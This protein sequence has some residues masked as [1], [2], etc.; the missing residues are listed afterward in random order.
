MSDDRDDID[1]ALRRAMAALD[2]E[3]PAGY[4]EALP[5]RTLAR[6]DD[7]AIGELPEE[8]TARPPR[9][10]QGLRPPADDDEDD[11]VFS[12]QIMA[13]VELPEPEGKLVA[14]PRDDRA[15]ASSAILRA[16]EQAADGGER[17]TIDPEPASTSS[18]RV[19]AVPID[20]D[21]ELGDPGETRIAGS[22]L[23]A[24]SASSMIAVLPVPPVEPAPPAAAAMGPRS[25]GAAAS[26]TEAGQVRRRRRV[27]AAVVGIGGI[28]LAAVAMMYLRAGEPAPRSAASSAASSAPSTVLNRGPTSPSAVSG[29]V[30][31]LA[32]GSAASADPVAGGNTISSAKPTGAA[33]GPGS[34]SG[35]TTAAAAGSGAVPGLTSG[36]ASGTGKLDE[37]LKRPG[38][39][40]PLSK[41]GGG[42]P[43]AQPGTGAA[44][45]GAGAVK[46][47]GADE[48]GKKLK[49]SK[50]RPDRTSLSG[51]DIERAMTAVAG[52]ARA[53]FAGTRGT[54]SLR[55]TV[56][57]SGRIV[58]VTVAGPFAGTPEGACVERA[59][60]TATFPPRSGAPRSFDYSYLLS[61]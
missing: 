52:Q 23:G 28:G 41:T 7:P 6:L 45:K 8:P 40:R 55:L 1:A 3:A 38:S 2:G 48:P 22:D 27:R 21:G 42:K 33:S 26:L 35:A 57:P 10:V 20:A 56:A 59:V 24:R 5:A 31:S 4:F 54:A 16:V 53:C 47:A 58:E 9:P 34:G 13:A 61:D 25:P 51:D 49:S 14:L 37:I 44:G 11:A 29:S 30:S 50:L 19:R 43:E 46:Q 60:R 12:S 18:V 39:A 32:G 36:P 17:G 15:S